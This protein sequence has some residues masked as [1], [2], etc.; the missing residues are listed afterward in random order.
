MSRAVATVQGAVSAVPCAHCG[1]PQNFAEL[2]RQRDEEGLDP[3]LPRGARVECDDC[4]KLSE[5]V[6]VRK[7]VVVRQA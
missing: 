2:E 7:V 5:V 4:G 3:E 6:D 1:K